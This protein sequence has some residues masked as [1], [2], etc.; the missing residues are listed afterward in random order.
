[1]PDFEANSRANAR[2]KLILLSVGVF[3]ANATVMALKG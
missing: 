3:L 2:G 1:L